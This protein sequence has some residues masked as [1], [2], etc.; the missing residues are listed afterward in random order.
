M[1]DVTK[2]P[3]CIGEFKRSSLTSTSYKMAGR[4]IG[5]TIKPQENLLIFG[6]WSPV[7][8]VIKRVSVDNEDSAIKAIA[9]FKYPS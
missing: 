5:C 2:M 3:L 6:T 9:N 1:I 8:A 4:Y 7:G